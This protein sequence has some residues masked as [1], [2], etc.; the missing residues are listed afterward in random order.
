M[1]EFLCEQLLR[2]PDSETSKQAAVALHLKS[3]QLKRPTEWLP[4]I[5]DLGTLPDNDT[6]TRL[7]SGTA[8]SSNRLAK[9]SAT[10]NGGSQSGQDE[11]QSIYLVCPHCPMS[12]ARR[13]CLVKFLS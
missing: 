7:G 8:T 5:P 10:R 6:K 12:D 3:T 13:I 11:R 1:R 2:H 4:Q 9:T